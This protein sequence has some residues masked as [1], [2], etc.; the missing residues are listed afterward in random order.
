MN[1]ESIRRSLIGAG[2]GALV[3]G[4]VSIYRSLLSEGSLLDYVGPIGMMT[5]IG[6][7]VGG[8]VGPLVGE[9]W[10]RSRERRERRGGGPGPS[11]P[12]GASSGETVPRGEGG[13]EA[14][15]LGSG[16]A[17]G[18][19]GS[20]QPFWFTLLVGL[21]VG[22]GVGSAWGR[23]WMGVGLGLALALLAR[24]VFR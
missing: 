12:V 24:R 11:E 3:F 18:P 5:V 17:E 22:W 10:R 8:L 14:N 21:G 15:P 19:G 6:G 13:T 1:P 4:A 20:R 9:A 2:V 16:P 7:T 23:V